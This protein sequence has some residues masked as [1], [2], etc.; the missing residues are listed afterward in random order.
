MLLLGIETS[1]DETAAAVVADGRRILSNVVSSQ[2]EVH[3]R[4]GGVVPEVASRHH[5]ENV[6]PVTRLAL[7]QAGLDAAGLDAIAVT[8]GP[9]LVGALL[10]GLQFAKGLAYAA[11]KPLVPV[12]HIA[13]HI[14]APLLAHGDAPLPALALVVSGGHTHVYLMPE[15][16][17]YRQ[18]GRTRDDAAGEAFDK[19]AK[20]LGLGYPG[21]PIV[22]RVAAGA[23]DRAVE[24][25]VAKM[26]DGRPDYSFS[27]LKTA[28]LQHVRARGILPL[29]R[30]PAS[31]DDVPRELRDLAASFQR[32]V[33]TAL[34]RRFEELARA[35]RPASLLLTGGVAANTL[36]RSEAAAL[37]QRLGLPLFVPPPAL[38]TDNAAMIAAAGWVNHRRGLRAGWDLN[39]EPHLPLGV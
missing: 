28:V 35:Q 12:H 14:E 21:G 3:A 36:L 11:G 29:A 38:S 34:L 6:A 32:A 33:V 24:F 22:D 2:V 27:G 30:P 23:D 19:V 26:S 4:Y 9:G 17:V 15:P 37:A 25:R 7:E 39:A 13:G 1:C 8:Y 10:V 20:L 18:L 5:L 31:P 16:G